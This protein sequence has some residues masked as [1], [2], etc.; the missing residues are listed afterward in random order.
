VPVLYLDSQWGEVS[1]ESEQNPV[2]VGG[3]DTLAYVIYTSGSTGRPKGVCICQRNLTNF[4]CAMQKAPGIRP[5]D[6]LLSVTSLSF[7]IAGLEI[8]LPLSVGA[9][10]VIVS[11]HSAANPQKLAE[12]SERHGVSLIQAT[13]STWQMLVHCADFLFAPGLTILC[14]GEA[15]PWDLAQRLLERTPVVWNMYGPTE[16]TIWSSVHRLTRTDSVVTIGRP[17]ANTRLYI[18]DA[19]LTPVPFGVAG[20]LLVAG[21][22]VARGYLNQAELTRSRFIPDPFGPPGAKMYRTGD[23]VR[24]RADGNIEYLGRMDQQ[25]KVRGFRIELG[26]IEAALT[27]YP[28]VAQAIV[29][30]REDASNEQRLVG[31]VVG[32]ALE[33]ATLKRALKRSLPEYMVPSALVILDQLPLTPNGKVDRKA[34]PA[35]DAGTEPHEYAAPKTDTEQRLTSIWAKLLQ[36]DGSRISTDVSFFALG[37]HSLMLVRLV[38]RIESELQVRLDIRDVVAMDDIARIAA[39]IDDVLA[40]RQPDL[41]M[42]AVPGADLAE[43][44]I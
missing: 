24:Y 31:Y 37:G 18:V 43:F 32:E 42:A 13:P 38:S 36:L 5:A 41:Q 10:T 26:E 27:R 16:T 19:S 35:P 34:L 6:V 4:I 21:H 23:L 17:I 1:G 29:L 2:R 33:A 9:T 22:G 39:M 40:L 11:R 7:D 44:E 20:E 14:G 30:A 3:P 12:E 28:G 25:V 8:Y 15:L